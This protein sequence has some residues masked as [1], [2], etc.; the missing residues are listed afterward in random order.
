MN[1][2]RIAQLLDEARY[3]EAHRMWLHA[4]QVYLRLIEDA[5]EEWS[6]RIRLGTLYLE[7]GNLQAAEQVLLQALRYDADNP[8]VLYA[9]GLACYQSDDLDRAVYYLLQLAGKGIPKVHYSLGLV[10]WRRTDLDSAER[11]FRLALDLQGDYTD[12]ALALGE[13]CMRLGKMGEAVQ[14]LRTATAFNL[15]DDS[16]AM[17]YGQALLGD[18]QWES[19]AGVFQGILRRS[20]EHDDAVHAL[21]GVWI[22]LNRLDDAE[23]LLKTVLLRQP[24]HPRT[25]VLLGRLAL[26]KSNRGKAESYFRS[27]LEI[28]PDN[29]EALEHLRYFTPHGNPAL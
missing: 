2:H 21:A 12:A 29:E 23:H 19:A 13:T 14:A 6:Y 27:A 20:P 17:T 24:R 22:R 16:L 10:Y 4:V 3:Y 11:H 1:E 5:P 28:E 25:L 9:L 26:V 7:M 8:D 18:G 15:T